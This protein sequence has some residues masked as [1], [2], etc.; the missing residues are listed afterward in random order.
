VKAID[1]YAG[2]V[3]ALDNSVELIADAK[4]K[5]DHRVLGPGGDAVAAAFDEPLVVNHQPAI[6]LPIHP[7]AATR[8][9]GNSLDN[10][11]VDNDAI[12]SGADGV[13]FEGFKKSGA[14]V[15]QYLF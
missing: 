3:I 7:I 2:A 4:G 15:M 14:I 11:F 10:S 6:V 13:R 9:A 1:V 8:G 5:A 12:H